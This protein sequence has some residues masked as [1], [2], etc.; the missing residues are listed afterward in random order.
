M[1]RYAAVFLMCL[2]WMIPVPARSSDSSA[3]PQVLMTADTSMAGL[4]NLYHAVVD[5]HDTRDALVI[6][7]PAM[8][9]LYGEA[10]DAPARDAVILPATG[11]EAIHV[12]LL[13][14][15]PDAFGAEY[16][17]ASLDDDALMRALEELE[18]HMRHGE[19]D[20]SAELA[21]EHV[22]RTGAETHA[23]RLMNIDPE[24]PHL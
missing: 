17:L 18:T 7:P 16:M 4:I 19:N 11:G 14:A 12:R 24:E 23:F 9:G 20:V 2:L 8:E 10:D 15:S 3:P 21:I 1:L 6:H 5:E 13:D 22:A